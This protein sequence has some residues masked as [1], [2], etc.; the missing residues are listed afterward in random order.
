MNFSRKRIIGQSAKTRKTWQSEEGYRIVWRT[1]VAGV[2]VPEA[3][4]PAVRIAVG[5]SEMWDTVGR[6][7]YRT[8]KKAEEACQRHYDL[9]MEVCEATC[10]TAIH[11]LIGNYSGIPLWAAKAMKPTLYEK[12]VTAQAAVK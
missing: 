6:V 3:Y 7:S 12:L 8:F 11:N 9:W 5:D 1:E 10:I 2:R 4:Q